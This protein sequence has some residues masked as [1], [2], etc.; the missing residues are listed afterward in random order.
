MIV[1]AALNKEGT[2][3]KAL[4]KAVE[5]FTILLALETMTELEEV[6]SREKFKRFILREDKIAILQLLAQN[7]ELIEINSD[8]KLCRDE[9][10]NKFLNLA[11]DGRADAH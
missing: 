10:D 5:E 11:I 1:S 3:R 7:G 2:S 8:V 9:D 4:Q 6:L